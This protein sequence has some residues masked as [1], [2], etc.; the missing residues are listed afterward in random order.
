MS[1][2]EKYHGFNPACV[3]GKPVELHGAEGR[4]EATG[5]GVAIL[6]RDAHGEDRPNPGHHFR[7]VY[8]RPRQRV[9]KVI[10]N[11]VESVELATLLDFLDM[12]EEQPR[13]RSWNHPDGASARISGCTDS[14]IIESKFTQAGLL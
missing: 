3:T 8:I 9:A 13:I 12:L 2:Y 5:R 6:T 11:F 1:Q 7:G 14:E 4:E 10:P